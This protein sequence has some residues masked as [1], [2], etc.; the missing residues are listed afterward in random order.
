MSNNTIQLDPPLRLETPLGFGLAMIYHTEWGG[1]NDQ[2]VVFLDTGF[3]WTF[4]NADVRR[5][6]EL[7]LGVQKPIMERPK[8]WDGD[9]VNAMREYFRNKKCPPKEKDEG[10]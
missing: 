3:I 1:H 4:D 6:E 5:C 10:R 9:P 8:G 2:W 7:T